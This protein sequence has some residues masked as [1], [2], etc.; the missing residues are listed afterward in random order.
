MR[1]RKKIIASLLPNECD[2]KLL[3]ESA[4]QV[5]STQREILD[6]FFKQKPHFSN[7]NTK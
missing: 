4:K 2:A 6:A 5:V 1:I 3:F 7:K